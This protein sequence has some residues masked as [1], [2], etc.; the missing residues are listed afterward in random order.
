MMNAT[1]THEPVFST[2]IRDIMTRKH[3][4]L[5][6]HQR[7]IIANII[8]KTPEKIC[9]KYH[10][11]RRTLQRI[12][13]KFGSPNSIQKKYNQLSADYHRL[14]SHSKKQDEI[15][16]VLQASDAKY[17]DPKKEKL[18]AADKLYPKFHPN[19]IISALGISRG[20]FFNHIYIGTRRIKPGSACG[21]RSSNR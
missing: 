17:T 8:N 11:S 2:I 16:A 14:L 6:T 19:A 13:D 15:I 18:N 7:I 21:G 4:H 3:K 1:K 12:R 10:I 5:K 20:G 9:E